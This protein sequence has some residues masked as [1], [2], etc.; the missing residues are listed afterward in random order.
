MS[1]LGGLGF[2]QVL[3]QVQQD[4]KILALRGMRRVSLALDETGILRYGVLASFIPIVRF[5]IQKDSVILF[6]RCVTRN[7]MSTY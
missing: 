1:P 4:A 7:K 2:N 5:A 6:Y 3:I